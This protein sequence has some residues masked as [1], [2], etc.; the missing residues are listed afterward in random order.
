[1]NT[2]TRWKQLMSKSL[3][4]LFF[5]APYFD[6]CCRIKKNKNKK[7]ITTLL[8][9]SKS[10]YFFLFASLQKRPPS[11]AAV[12]TLQLCQK[13][14]Q[15]LCGGRRERE[16]EKKQSICS[17]PTRGGRISYTAAA[18]RRE[19]ALLLLSASLC[20][21]TPQIQTRQWGFLSQQDLS[22][23]QHCVAKT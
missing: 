23:S 15:C 4:S 22:I 2:L 6:C 21:R 8:L 12:Q 16:R 1:M 9:S 7:K 17:N 3:A 13:L 19:W 5:P 20:T 14:E 10:R 11:S 18:R